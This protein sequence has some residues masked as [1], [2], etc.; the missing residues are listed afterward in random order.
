MNPVSE[1]SEGVQR[2]VLLTSKGTKLVGHQ[3]VQA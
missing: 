1:D 2:G 3:L